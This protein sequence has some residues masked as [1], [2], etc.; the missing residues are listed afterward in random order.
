MP[1]ERATSE[2]LQEVVDSGR[3]MYEAGR[4]MVRGFQRLRGAEDGEWRIGEHPYLLLGLSV[5][6]LLLI[7]AM[8]RNRD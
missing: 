7:S 1:I 3:M 6:A 4:R 5:G 2:A 8:I